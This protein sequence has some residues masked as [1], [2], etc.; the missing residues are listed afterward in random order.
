[1]FNHS[2][3]VF[4]AELSTKGKNIMSFIRLLG[5]NIKNTLKDEF[6]KLTYQ[7]KRDHTY[8]NL[9]GEDYNKVSLLLQKIPGI[10]KFSKVVEIEKEIDTIVDTSFELI[11]ESNVK[12]FKIATK[13]ID[14][15]FPFHSDEVNRK[16]ASKV[17][18]EIDGI[19][20]DVKNP[21]LKLNVMI[22]ESKTYIY[23]DTIKGLG[24]YPVGIQGKGLMLISGGIDSP[25]ASYLLLRRGLKLEYIHF[26][27]PPYTSEKVIEKIKNLLGKLNFYQ[28]DIKLHIVPFTETQLEIYKHVPTSYAITIMRRMMLR[29]S[30]R[31][32]IKRRAPVICT[33]ESIGQVASQTLQSVNAI[34][35][36]INIPVLRPLTSYDKLDIINIAEKIDT[37]NISILPYE[38]CCTIF[39]TKDPTTCPR[40]DK[41]EFYESKFDYQTLI[42][43][44]FDNIETVI[45]SN[46]KEDELL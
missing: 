24:G 18:K 38:D 28:G 22:R 17:L 44:A 43:K 16:I 9:N 32:A 36:V 46:K 25:V 15:L 10:Q 27:A 40:V 14:K 39:E 1:M 20:V 21:E 41:C 45:V 35:R 13:R 7:V 29:I 3:I 4:Y 42:D 23:G 33:G 31:L 6:P 2:I 26:Q 34:E 5:Q 8:I 12:T 37:Y 19:K 11:K 30:E